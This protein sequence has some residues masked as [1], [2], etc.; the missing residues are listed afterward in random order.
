LGWGAGGGGGGGPRPGDFYFI[1][2]LEIGLLAIP[3]GE[4]MTLPQT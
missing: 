4:V 2:D 1:P 3:G